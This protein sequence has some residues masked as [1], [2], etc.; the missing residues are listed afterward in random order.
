MSALLLFFA[1]THIYLV[2]DAPVRGLDLPG[3][4]VD[5]E[6]GGEGRPDGHAELVGLLLVD[7]AV[8]GAE[9]GEVELPLGLEAE[10][11][12]ADPLGEVARDAALLP[13]QVHLA[14]AL[15]AHVH[16]EVLPVPLHR[17]Q[18]LVLV[19]GSGVLNK[20][21]IRLEFVIEN[22]TVV[23]KRCDCCDMLSKEVLCLLYF[24]LDPATALVPLCAE[25]SF[26][27]CEVVNVIKLARSTEALKLPEEKLGPVPRP[28]CS[29][30]AHELLP[31]HHFVLWP[32]VHAVEKCDVGAGLHLALD[33]GAQ[34]VL[35]GV[36]RL[37]VDPPHV[38]V[39][40]DQTA[41]IR[42]QYPETLA[43]IDVLLQW[44][45]I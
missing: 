19:D 1:F 4:E 33:G 34:R 37:P 9:H 21:G 6:P 3:V 43:G 20:E 38:Q 30:L 26:L 7:E 41:L 42:K 14:E 31:A 8:L 28:E 23:E 2:S 18:V 25:D 17:R 24:R 44:N 22:I 40:Q 39:E 29:R 13:H 5:V 35:S 32:F 10:L 12:E 11:D 27:P 16:Q 15:A 36:G 45:N